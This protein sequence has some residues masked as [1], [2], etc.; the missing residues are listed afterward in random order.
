[1]IKAA[2]LKPVTTGDM[3]IVNNV[4]TNGHQNI[5]IEHS[6]E[7]NLVPHVVES[8]ACQMVDLDDFI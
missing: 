5:K 1:M 6:E 4:L 7:E 2:A 3:N 8:L